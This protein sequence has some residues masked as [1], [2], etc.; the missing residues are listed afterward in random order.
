MEIAIVTN[1]GMFPFFVICMY[2][3]QFETLQLTLFFF[4]PAA[5]GEM[6]ENGMYSGVRFAD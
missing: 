1:A 3:F 5:R 6:K 2:S 4:R